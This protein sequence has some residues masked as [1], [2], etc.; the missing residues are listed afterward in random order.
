MKCGLIKQNHVGLS[1]IRESLHIKKQ[2][3]YFELYWR[4][5][6]GNHCISDLSGE[7]LNQPLLN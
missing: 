4:I 5:L 6:P 1:W 2:I 7:I 3:S